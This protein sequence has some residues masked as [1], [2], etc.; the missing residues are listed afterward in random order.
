V[1]I[2]AKTRRRRSAKR[3]RTVRFIGRLLL[4]EKLGFTTAKCGKE[5][6]PMIGLRV[7]ISDPSF[8]SVTLCMDEKEEEEE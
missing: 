7:S 3:G 5:N 6:E 2:A 4:T 8:S 1:S